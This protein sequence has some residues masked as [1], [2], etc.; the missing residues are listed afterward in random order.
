MADVL[1]QVFD[2]VLYIVA[3]SQNQLWPLWMRARASQVRFGQG[4]E[5]LVDVSLSCPNS[6]VGVI[7]ASGDNHTVMQVAFR[8]S[9][10]RGTTR[11]I[12]YALCKNENATIRGGSG[13]I[14]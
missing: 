7:V 5:K 6:S 10:N 13:I 9:I 1:A 14:L 4:I 8:S 12:V 3:Y 11:V 2:G